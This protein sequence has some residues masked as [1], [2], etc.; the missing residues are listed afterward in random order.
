MLACIQLHKCSADF[1]HD[2]TNLVVPAFCCDSFVHMGQLA[3]AFLHG[4]SF[5]QSIKWLTVLGESWYPTDKKFTPI[6][7]R[8]GLLPT[9]KAFPKGTTARIFFT[10]SHQVC[11]GTPVLRRVQ[12]L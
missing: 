10:E 8:Q 1:V 9:C 11:N 3:C 4:L 7:Y 6:S 12:M 2:S 5:D